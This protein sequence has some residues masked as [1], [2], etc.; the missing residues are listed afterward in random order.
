[1]TVCCSKQTV[2]IPQ[3]GQV[4][5]GSGEVVNSLDFYPVALTS[6]SCFYFR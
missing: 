3:T 5:D 1:M 2:G 6:L 4:L